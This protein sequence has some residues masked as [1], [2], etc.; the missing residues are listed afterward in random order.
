MAGGQTSF[1]YG[2]SLWTDMFNATKS[3]YSAKLIDM[4]PRV[5]PLLDKMTKSGNIEAKEGAVGKRNVEMVLAR[6]IRNMKWIKFDDTIDAECYNLTDRIEWDWKF[7]VQSFKL[8]DKVL[9]VNKSSEIADLLDMHHKALREGITR[10]LAVQIY[11]S[12]LDYDADNNTWTQNNLQMGGLQYLVNDNPYVNDLRVLGMR[13]GGLPGDRFEFWRNRAGQWLIP[14][15]STNPPALING[16]PTWPATVDAQ[17]EALVSAMRHM[18]QIVDVGNNGIDGIYTNHFFYDLYVYYMQKRLQINNVAGEKKDVG[19]SSVSFMGVPL[20]LD[21]YCPPNKMY[22]IDSKELHFKFLQGENFKHETKEVPNQFAKKYFVT[23]IGNF[24]TTRVRN[25]G[26]LVINKQA[27]D[28][29]LGNLYTGTQPAGIL[30]ADSQNICNFDAFIDADYEYP[31]SP[32]QWVTGYNFA[33]E[34]SDYSA[35]G[36]YNPENDNFPNVQP[37]PDHTG[38]LGRQAAQKSNKSSK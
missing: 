26:V 16:S 12:G 31:K 24:T 37:T 20:Y 4:L 35:S 27:E 22:F 15:S 7:C 36:M 30:P 29:S 32:A 6:P 28:N 33:S 3:Y 25:M 21:R 10:D 9:S 38:S 5:H 8:F 23:F 11:S 19:F 14:T 18:I 1:S 13:R 17:A 2:A 34:R